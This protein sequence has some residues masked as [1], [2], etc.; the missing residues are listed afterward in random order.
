MSPAPFRLLLLTLALALPAPRFAVAQ[1]PDED[2]PGRR[3]IGIFAADVRVALPS[4]DQDPAIA[5]RLG[6]TQENLPGRGYGLVLGAHVYP[7]RLGPA[8]VGIGGEMMRSRGRRTAEPATQGGP[9]GPTVRT[10]FSSMSP[11][12]S[13]NFGASEGWSYLSAGLGW[14]RFSVDRENTTAPGTPPEATPDAPRRRTL[15]YGGG[16]RWFAR[17]H[18]AFAIDLRFYSLSPQEADG[19]HPAMPQT[20]RLVLSAGVA[21]K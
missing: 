13:L 2:L 15:N 3:P 12:I 20:R 14:A 21:F 18:L 19:P 16:A 5:Q 6:V 10:Q 8:T 1:V 9:E 11:Q 7:L 4:F 17:P